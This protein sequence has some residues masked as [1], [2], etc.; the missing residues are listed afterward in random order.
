MYQP[1]S[2]GSQ[3]TFSQQADS[4]EQK[5]QAW[6]K[7]AAAWQK[8]DPAESERCLDMAATLEGHARHLRAQAQK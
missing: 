5:A 4:A 8:S 7:S 6:R 2:T 3:M 1:L